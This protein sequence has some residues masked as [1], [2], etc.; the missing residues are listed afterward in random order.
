MSQMPDSG[1]PPVYAAPPQKGWFGRNWWWV[2]PGGVLLPMCICG[3]LCGGLGYFGLK[4]IENSEPYKLAFE[5]AKQ[6]PEVVDAL[7]EPIEKTGVPFG[8]ISA[9]TGEGENADIQFSIKGPKGSARVD[10]HSHKDFGEP[11]WTLERLI[12]TPE[13]GAAIIIIDDGSARPD[14]GASGDMPANNLGAEES[15]TESPEKEQP[16]EEK[17]SETSPE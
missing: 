17:S 11:Q 1:L 7:G 10:S 16:A 2:I 4:Q 15:E 9:G 6:D 12:V 3:S 5:G 13:G 14:E 8:A